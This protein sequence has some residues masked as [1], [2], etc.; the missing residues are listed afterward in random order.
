M[1]DY[2]VRKD[3]FRKYFGSGIILTIFFIQSIILALNSLSIGNLK[4]RG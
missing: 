4:T 3:Y 2:V 1:D